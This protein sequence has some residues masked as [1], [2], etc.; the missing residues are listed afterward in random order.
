MG[1]KIRIE[2]RRTN[3]VGMAEYGG[4]CRHMVDGLVDYKMCAHNYSC[5]RCPFD[6]MVADEIVTQPAAQTTLPEAVGF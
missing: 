4:K 6:Q 5:R 2:T 1:K 3:L